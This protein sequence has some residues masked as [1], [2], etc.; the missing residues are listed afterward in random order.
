MRVKCLSNRMTLEQ[1]QHL[2]V[3]QGIDFEYPFEIGGEYVVLGISSKSGCNE[4]VMFLMPYFYALLAPSCLFEIIDERPSQ[5]WRIKKR[6]GYDIEL[7]PEE[8]YGD[9]FFDDL[10]DRAEDAVKIYDNIVKKIEQEFEC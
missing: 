3:A 10:T 1:S 7:W 9:Y 5:Y 6:N 4:S 2:G 8:F